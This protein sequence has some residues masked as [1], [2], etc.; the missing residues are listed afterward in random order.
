MA[1]EF[2]VVVIG[3]GAV[4][5]N[6][7]AR[8][9]G[10]GLEVALVEHELLGGECSYW[11]CMP[12]K[13][14]LRPGEVLAA[15]R[16]VPAA[17]G[18]VTGGVD[19]E[20]TLSSR[21]ALSSHLDDTDQ[22]EWVASAGITLVR[23]RGCLDGDRRVVVHAE[24]GGDRQLSARRAVVLATGSRAAMPPIPGLADSWPWDNRD[25]TQVRQI[26]SRLA[27][28]GGGVVACELAQAFKRLGA[29]EVTVLEVADRLLAHEEPF[30]GEEVAAALVRD[31]VDV[32]TR[33]QVTEVDR[34]GPDAPVTLTI[35]D[36]SLEADELLVAT[37]R[38]AV[39]DDVGLETVGL[40]PGGY[41]EVDDELRVTGVAD[42]WLYAVGDVNG[43]NLLTHMG[44]Y[45]A[46]IA[47]DVI[48]AQQGSARADHVANTRVVF[49][50][51]QVAAVGRTEQQARDQG[52]AVRT[53]NVGST[54]NAGG[55]LLGEGLDGTSKLVIDAD[56]ETVLG[57]TF[58][59]PGV[60]ELLHAATV[61]VVGELPLSTLW[62]AVPA[63]P[64][65]SE[66]WLRLLEEAGL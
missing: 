22:A 16:A 18:A 4:G 21:D 63:F 9:A 66:L 19:V 12:S 41:L 33:V 3:G 57:A 53:V 40:G 5:E 54:A 13:A 15:A 38:R 6:A 55:A 44:K 37:G 34:G 64:T 52:F 48:A 28:I 46:R 11:A 2:D 7:A 24:D 43:R 23:G 25:A 65:I 29:R 58:T 20:R 36:E 1:E 14:L 31:G 56:R 60:G 10:H 62:H 26:P 42:G 27:I 50:D 35:D 8:A 51:P 30:A 59:G 39:T 47:G 49:T 32:R 45:Q 17:A 61:A